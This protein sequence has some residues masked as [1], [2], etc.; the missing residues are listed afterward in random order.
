MCRGS[1]GASVR[2]DRRFS[3]RH[4]HEEFTAMLY[5]CPCNTALTSEFH[6][7]PQA[8]VGVSVQSSLL[9]IRMSLCTALSEE[10]YVRN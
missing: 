8:V 2:L 9:L 5:L 6:E 1:L 4:S 10:I 7:I 3:P